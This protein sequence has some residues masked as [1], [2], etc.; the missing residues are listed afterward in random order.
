MIQVCMKWLQK[1]MWTLKKGPRFHPNGTF[2]RWWKTAQRPKPDRQ[3]TSLL[4]SLQMEC[5]DSSHFFC[6]SFLQYAF[7]PFLLST[8][9]LMCKAR[10]NKLL[11]L[12]NDPG[13][14][15]TI[16]RLISSFAGAGARYSF[17]LALNLITTSFWVDYIKTV[18]YN[19]FMPWSKKKDRCVNQQLLPQW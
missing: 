11:N 14:N 8:R 15:D 9:K 17:L 7:W 5:G 6:I 4:S 18:I 19:T 12:L 2:E 1:A 3:F 16:P 10:Q 13:R